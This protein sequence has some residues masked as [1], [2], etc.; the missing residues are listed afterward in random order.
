MYI[1]WIEDKISLLNIEINNIE[2]RKREISNK[3]K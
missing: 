2:N 1:D 3:K